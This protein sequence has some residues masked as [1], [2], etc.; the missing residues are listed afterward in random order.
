MRHDDYQAALDRLQNAA[1]AYYHGD[2]LEMTDADYDDLLRQVAAYERDNGLSS[3][4]TS[5]VA[6]GTTA[7]GADYQHAH[8]M[9]S[10][11]N[12]MAGTG[13]LDNW[14]RKSSA[15]TLF[16]VEPKL[17][18]LAISAT[19]ESGQLTAVAT[20]GDGV[21]GELVTS[22]ASQVAGLPQQLAEPFTGEI[23]GELVLTETDF[24]EANQLRELHGDRP[25]AN[26]RNG[27]AGALRGADS[28]NYVIPLSFGAYGV[29]GT[30]MT[31]HV[32][33]MRHIETL[34]VQTARQLCGFN[35]RT[36]TIADVQAE[37]DR[38]E[39]AR[40]SLPAAIDGAVVKLDDLSTYESLGA[41]SKAPRWA[42]AYK[43]AAQ[44]VSTVLEDIV[45]QV[46]RTGV[47]TP[48]ALVAP[49]NVAGVTVTRST[50]SNPTQ[51]ELK[52]L[53]VGAT[54]ILRRAGD[55]IPEIVD[56]IRDDTYDRLPV[57][58][59]PTACPICNADLDY[60]SVRVRCSTRGACVSRER[61]IYAASRKCYDIEGLS[62]ATVDLL[63]DN[64]L[65]ADFA[66]L[67]ALTER[68]LIPLDRVGDRKAQNLVAAIQGSK[69]QPLDRFLTSL[70]IETFGRSL[71]RRVVAQHPTL[72]Q[73][74]AL[75]E[76]ELAAIEGIGP[77][78]A[79]SIIDGFNDRADLITKMVAAGLR[80]DA[81]QAV[82]PVDSAV[83]GKKVVV[84]GSLPGY[85]RDGV[86]D[87]VEALGAIS[88]SSVSKSTDLLVIGEK[89]GA[90]K[91]TKAAELGIPTMSAAEF[92]ALM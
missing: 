11:D 14:L 10:L 23:R 75:S 87:A 42:V 27:A 68:D 52:G 50:V 60:D 8:P 70:G 13:D 51:V 81:E 35:H 41:T 55:V 6:A 80:T 71:S 43:Y 47:L 16:A 29:A 34:G 1:Q 3:S 21:T 73:V 84:T 37:I 38:I 5:R 92:L 45:L 88:T 65:I 19:Y 2:T 74:L 28:R 44:E 58:T 7:E 76:R 40:F 25:F 46:G 49:V 20:R 59:A 56:V 36:F 89:P 82:T 72:D 67:Y 86:R 26:P 33:A 30:G 54:V 18:G 22:R 90:S 69:T 62:A 85:T 91:V 32:A 15:D 4:I 77:S 31:S 53:R 63:L 78:R 61:I 48:V 24:V 83:A 64:G 66:D 17:D 39:A 57:W 79:A 9:L 12:A